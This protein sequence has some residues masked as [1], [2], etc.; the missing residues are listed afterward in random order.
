SFHGERFVLFAS[1]PLSILAAWAIEGFMSWRWIGY[2]LALMVIILT[3]ING[4]NAIRTVLTPI[5]NSTWDEALTKIKTDTP[6]DSIINTW[7]APGHFIK[8]IA[9]RSVPFDGAS[10]DQGPIGYWMANMFLSQDEAQARGILRM[11]NSSGNKPAE[12]LV[13]CGLKLSDATSLL[14]S[15]AAQNKTDAAQTL[16]GIIND[17][18]IKTLLHMTH[19]QKPHSYV[20]AYTE[21]IDD[22]MML[23]FTSRWNIKKIEDINADPQQLQ[24]VPKT[25]SPDFIDFLWRTMGGAPKYSERL[26]LLGQKNSLLVFKENLEI[27]LD[28]M[29]AK[30]QSLK[31]GQGLPLSIFYLKD[32]KIVEHENPEGSLNYS[33][34]LYKEDGQYAAR[35][36]DRTLANSLI[37]KLYYFDGQ[38]LEYFKPLVLSHDLTGRTRIKVFQVIY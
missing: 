13:K 26:P 32:G 14:L 12:Y 25:N 29:E 20:L 27:D 33:V 2:G 16:K 1:I 9:H 5:F 24:A 11:I 37:M 6:Q 35:L 19:G 17:E 18:Q 30:I 7:W 34:I 21:L 31:Y 38:G 4:N 28:T 10:L 36:M 23:A 8:G 15:I 22:N 3:L